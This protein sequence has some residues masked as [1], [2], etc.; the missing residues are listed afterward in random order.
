MTRLNPITVRPI[1]DKK[2]PL[3]QLFIKLLADAVKRDEESTKKLF[4]L[5]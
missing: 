2:H 1:Q 3:S 4:N 5:K